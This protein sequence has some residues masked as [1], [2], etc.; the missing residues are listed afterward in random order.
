[1]V[2][3]TLQTGKPEQRQAEI[4]N[5][6]IASQI[7]EDV[8]PKRWTLEAENIGLGRW[9]QVLLRLQRL[10]VSAASETLLVP[11]WRRILYGKRQNFALRQSI[12]ISRSAAPATKSN[13]PTSP[14][15][16]HATQNESHDW[17]ASHMRRHLQCA[18]QAKSTSNLTKYCACHE[19]LSSRF[20]RK[21]PELL[22]PI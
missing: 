4:A 6:C 10:Y 1:M 14:N 3:H 5:L 8:Q 9:S 11:S 15:T 12:Q 13:T 19:I 7:Q 22:P 2:F 16:A 20:K 17:S 18:E 21:I